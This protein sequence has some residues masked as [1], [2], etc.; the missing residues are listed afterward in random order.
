M[1][2][3]VCAYKLKE[4]NM[5][6]ETRDHTPSVTHHQHIAPHLFEEYAR[7]RDPMPEVPPI[8]MEHDDS[9]PAGDELVMI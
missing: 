3:S 9:G 8:P 4:P 6:R 1:A 7:E 5:S 2:I